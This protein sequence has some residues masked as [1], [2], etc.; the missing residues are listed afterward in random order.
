MNNTTN[1]I[2]NNTI[3]PIDNNTTNPIDKNILSI[4]LSYLDQN[5]QNCIK[6]SKDIVELFDKTYGTFINRKNSIGDFDKDVPTTISKIKN[7]ISDIFTDN[8]THVIIYYSGHGYQYNNLTNTSNT[9]TSDKADSDGKEE[10]LVISNE[11][12]KD[13]DL[14]NI[15]FDNL[16]TVTKS[17]LILDC[18]FAGGIID[19]I[20]KFSLKFKNLIVFAGCS[21]D[22]YSIIDLGITNSVFTKIFKESPGL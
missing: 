15:L 11:L 13:D 3:N 22:E 18:C 16:N 2:D 19:Y 21:E 17:M 6:D 14:T 5:M 8:P 7:S 20:K 9:K 4:G 12:F 10:S 1:P